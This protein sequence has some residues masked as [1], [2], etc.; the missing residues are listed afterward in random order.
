MTRGTALVGVLGHVDHGKTALVQALTG[1]D[2]DRLPEERRRGISIALGFALLTTPDGAAIDLVDVPGHERLVRT[3]VAGATSIEAALLVV[4]AAEGVRPQTVEHAEIAAL[5]GVRRGVVAVTRCDLAG[6]RLGASGEAAR[7]LLDRL[8]LGGWPVIATSAVTGAGLPALQG[9]L[10]DL[11]HP[12]AAGEAGCAWL[13]VD[14]V[15]TLAGV[16]TVVTGTLRGGQLAVGET[17]ELLPSGRRARIR[18]LQTH[19]AAAERAGPGRRTAVALRGVERSA[20]SP[21]DSIASPGLLLASGRLD[22]RVTLLASASRPLAD[23]A[24]VRL[25]CGTAECHARVRLLG[26]RRLDPGAST[27]AQ[28][29][30][31]APL[32]VPTRATFILRLPSPPSTVGGGVVLDPCPPRRRAADLAMLERVAGTTTPL[33]AAAARLGAA[34]P[35]GVDAGE[36]AR[37]AGLPATA[38]PARLA[39]I[40][41]VALPGG[42]VL[43][44]GALAA[45]TEAVLTMLERERRLDPA[46]PGPAREV[47]RRALPAAAPAEALVAHLVATGRLIGEAGRLRRAGPDEASVP[48]P[49]AELALLA[50]LERRFRAGGLAPPDMAEVGAGERRRLHAMQVLV[51]R[52]VLVRAPDAV[53]KRE[54]L[55]HRDA[56]AAARRILRA[57]FAS[58]RGGFLAGECGR[59]LGISRRYSIPLLERLDAERFTRR[60]GDRRHVVDLS[61]TDGQAAG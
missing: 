46:G 22:A 34:T 42:T 51:R 40:D 25:L 54:I 5:L 18:S 37:L 14:R 24:A 16:G 26:Q 13:P 31:D 56:L 9:A 32:A 11:A 50:E 35:A 23:G 2:T 53:Q 44:R 52:G 12:A 28:L 21:G 45:L 60:E 4:D 15:F 38:L 8:G 17:V 6:A 27:V 57:H 43:H 10:A 61:E 55:F 36:L 1:T 29:R 49:A 19:G 33:A 58:R 7:V 59:L 30:L 47:L 20:L 39:E 41:G 48:L 3:M